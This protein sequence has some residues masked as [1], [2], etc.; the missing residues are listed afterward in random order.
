MEAITFTALVDHFRSNLWGHHL[1][2]PDE[3]AQQFIE[4]DNRRVICTLNDQHTIQAALMPKQDHFFIL[5]NKAIRDK[6]GLSVGDEVQ[7]KLVKDQST[8]GMDMPEEFD[9]LLGQDEAA[10]A[11]FEALTPGKQ[12]SLIYIVKKMKR[13][14]SRLSKALAITDYLR[15]TQG[16]I[17]FKALNEVIKHY[18]QQAKGW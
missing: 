17:D 18:N 15:S 5:L 4:G 1:L 2:V 14:E 6:L 3:I 9:V 10:K 12:R 13:P 7:V 16:P 11:R 8:Y